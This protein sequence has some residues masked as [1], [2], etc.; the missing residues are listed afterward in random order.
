[1][2][3]NILDVGYYYD[4]LFQAVSTQKLIVD[5]YHSQVR[6]LFSVSLFHR[7]FPVMNVHYVGA[8][9]VY[10]LY[11]FFF[12]FG[13]SLFVL[14][15]FSLLCG[16]MTIVLSFLFAL[17]YFSLRVACISCLLLAT[18]PSLIFFSRYDFGPI[19]VQNILKLILLLI[20]F[21]IIH[22]VRVRSV[23][24]RWWIVVLFG[25]MAGLLVWDK[26]NG[27]WL[28]GPLFL[29]VLSEFTVSRVKNG[30]FLLSG[31]F[32]GVLP[33]LLFLFSFTRM[34]FGERGSG[35]SPVN[36]IAPAAY[37]GRLSFYF[38]QIVSEILYRLQVLWETLSGSGVPNLHLLRVPIN[39]GVLGF[40]FLI[41]L[42]VVAWWCWRGW[43]PFGY[44]F[45]YVLILFLCEIVLILMTPDAHWEHHMLFLWPF[46]HFI[47]GVVLSEVLSTRLIVMILCVVVFFNVQVLYR[48]Q[49][50]LQANRLSEWWG[51]T[52][53]IQLARYLEREYRGRS[54]VDVDWGLSVPLAFISRGELSI[55][56]LKMLFKPHCEIIEESLSLDTQVYILYKSRWNSF[57]S[58]YR[59]CR[60]PFV[61]YRFREEDVGKFKILEKQ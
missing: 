19:G 43:Y 18:D 39:G 26:L 6:E 53:T 35:A 51:G 29:L 24:V 47:V 52:D 14:R 4:E 61:L 17:R 1:V 5:D 30:F 40:V 46:P 13:D 54:L 59:D 42:I 50:S 12:F 27:V 20:G 33:F 23:V 28:V 60:N 49:L 41:A 38:W 9:K 31:F 56:D 32:V 55:S 2:L 15:V 36:G 22:Q 3:W 7:S 21:Y 8:L 44:V 37:T 11:P 58:D 45:K 25:L 16:G 48:F 57:L 34:F 10:L